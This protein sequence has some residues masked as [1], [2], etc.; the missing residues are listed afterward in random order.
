MTRDYLIAQ[1]RNGH[2]FAPRQLEYVGKDNALFVVQ[3]IPA[4]DHFKK[5]VILRRRFH[6]LFPQII[7]IGSKDC[8]S[9]LGKINPALIFRVIPEE[10]PVNT[11]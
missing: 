1:L 5:P 2:A 10:L 11:R 6:E 3:V 7:A 9:I 4:D 8:M